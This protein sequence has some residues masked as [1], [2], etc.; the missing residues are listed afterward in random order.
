ML[1]RVWGG[2]ISPEITEKSL[3]NK[4]SGVGEREKSS[5]GQGGKG[6][7]SPEK[8][9]KALLNNQ[10]GVR[11]RRS[12]ADQ[13]GGGMSSPEMTK[14]TQPGARERNKRDIYEQ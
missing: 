9:I 2:N 10:S 1:N 4:K 7:I 12:S 8:T 3:L 11:E 14:N 5:S 13:D 6:S